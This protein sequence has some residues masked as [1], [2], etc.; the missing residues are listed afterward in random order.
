MK[1]SLEDERRALLE[2]IEASRA[3]YRRMLAGE[4]DFVGSHAPARASGT[5][6]RTYPQSRTMQWILD[7][8]L[9]VAGGVA[10]LVL[11][12]PRIVGSGK[13]AAA[14]RSAGQH[15]EA[16]A[17]GGTLR[18]LLT[19]AALLLRDPA[20]LRAA[21]RFA[22]SAWQWMRQRRRARLPVAHASAAM[23]M[24]ANSAPAPL[25]TPPRAGT[26]PH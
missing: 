10:L 1:P 7:H 6:S 21:T 15:P 8:P 23:T 20:R 17:S 3:V 13:R 2:Q 4:P 12:A 18:A 19:V 9:W 14:R 24:P 5:S 26:R 11:L 16:A 22:G 25:A